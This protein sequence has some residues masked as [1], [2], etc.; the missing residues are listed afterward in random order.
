MGEL[1]VILRPY[2]A[3]TQSVRLGDL[4]KFQESMAAHEKTFEAHQTLSLIKRLRHNVIKTGLRAINVS[5]SAI[6]LD[7]I[8]EKSVSSTGMLQMVLWR[9][10]SRTGLSM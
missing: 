4:T 3:I 10:R 8:A 5:Y 2:F 1:R 9:R 7:D 6:H